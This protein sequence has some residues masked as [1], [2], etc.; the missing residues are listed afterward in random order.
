[1]EEIKS[2]KELG[3]SRSAGTRVFKSSTVAARSGFEVGRA[4][5]GP[6]TGGGDARRRGVGSGLTYG[7]GR[8]LYGIFGTRSRDKGGNSLISTRVLNP[9]DQT[10]VL[11]NAVAAKWETPANNKLG[12]VG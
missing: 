9:D 2:S 11:L 6:G 10:S 4:D 12:G 5:A 1:M 7:C 3:S 8:A